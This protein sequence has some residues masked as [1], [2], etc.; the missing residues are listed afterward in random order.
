MK[1]NKYTP[2]KCIPGISVICA[3]MMSV[4]N[5]GVAAGHENAAFTDKFMIR[6]AAY[7]VQDADTQI[8]VANSTSGV[9]VGYSFN[10]DLGGEDNVTIPRLDAYYRF[11]DRHR[12]DFSTFTIKRDGRRVLTIDVD[13]ED[14]TYNIGDTLVSDIEYNLVKVGYGYSFYRSDRVELGL[15]AGLNVTSYDFEFQLADGSRQGKADASGPLP[16][17][18]IFMSYQITPDWSL[19]YISESFYISID[20]ALKGSFT[21]NEFDIQYRLSRSFVLGAGLTRFSSDLSADD[22]GW[23]GRVVDSHRGMLVYGAYYL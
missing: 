6:L 5:I 23:Q 4:P 7:S 14:Q 11:N 1:K 16:M 20:D 8:A 17:F 22:S 2:V 10:N 21:N 18:G 15:S 12:I 9:G 3:A 13:L 19:H